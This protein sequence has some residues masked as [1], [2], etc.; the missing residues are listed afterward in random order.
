MNEVDVFEVKRLVP[1]V[2]E[3]HRDD[4]YMDNEH[5]GFFSSVCNAFDFIEKRVK[6]NYGSYDEYCIIR[7]QVD[8]FNMAMTY[9]E[10]QRKKQLDYFNK[11][12]EGDIDG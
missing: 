5:L 12:Q 8:C 9:V 11:K 4:C 2:N 3:Y 1:R 7:I 6:S 10:E